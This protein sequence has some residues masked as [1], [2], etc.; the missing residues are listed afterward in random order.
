MKTLTLDK[1]TREQAIDYAN[2]D[3]EMHG[4]EKGSPQWKKAF[5]HYLSFSI[6]TMT[7]GRNPRR[8]NPRDDLTWPDIFGSQGFVTKVASNFKGKRGERPSPTEIAERVKGAVTTLSYLYLNGIYGM[9]TTTDVSAS[10]KIPAKDMSDLQFADG[11]A[12]VRNHD[13]IMNQLV[14]TLVETAVYEFLLPF[15]TMPKSDIDAILDQVTIENSQSNKKI[16]TAKLMAEFRT[17][18]EKRVRQAIGSRLKNLS[19]KNLV[20]GKE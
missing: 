2:T 12:E 15:F 6:G 13:V 14:M 9:K 16:D 1:N 20:L 3:A 17:Q 10:G 7:V 8:A 18:M 11:D 4:H 5:K 19:F